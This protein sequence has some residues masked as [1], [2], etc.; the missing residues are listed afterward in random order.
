MFHWLRS[1]L[2]RWCAAGLLL[3]YLG[4]CAL[5]AAGTYVDNFDGAA[6]SIAARNLAFHGRYGVWD[7]QTFRCWPADWSTGPTLMLP[8]AATYRL[9]GDG[10]FTANYGC[11][12][13][14]L[15][16]LALYLVL[17]VR[18]VVLP[19]GF[20]ALVTA[21]GLLAAVTGRMDGGV[22]FEITFSR[23]C[24]EILAGLLLL[25]ATV[26]TFGPEPSRRSAVLGGT[27]AALAV[28]TKFVTVMPVACLAGTIGVLVLRGRKPVSTLVL[29]CLAAAA[30]AGSFELLKLVSL[31]SWRAYLVNLREFRQFLTTHGSSGLSAG[32]LTCLTNFRTHLAIFCAHLGNFTVPL[33]L[34]LLLLPWSLY[35]VL[36]S[37]DV[38]PGDCIALALG[39]QTSALFGWWFFLSHSEWVRHILPGLVLLPLW[40]AHLVSA[41]AERFSNPGARTALFGS[42]VLACLLPALSPG[43][44]EPIVWP[45]PTTRVTERTEALFRTAEKIKAL[46]ATH[47]D[48]RFFSAGF[49]RHWD[50]QSVT[51]VSLFDVLDPRTL[52]GP[53]DPGPNYLITSDLFNLEHNPTITELARA[54]SAR[55]VF[56]DGSFRIDELPAAREIPKSK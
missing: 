4:S 53:N 47:P 35:R 14:C 24:G 39:L 21:I 18:R 17:A 43:T 13:C 11:A 54:A 30:V 28:Y 15:S 33:L 6:Q 55:P 45:T 22:N 50:I 27:L 7:F 9:L 37:R 20:L 52:P 41:E 26:V 49:W 10:P 46:R 40:G 3:G 42:W 23:P 25:T 31:G 36:L 44:T 29:W 34:P 48:A 1:S 51:D 16:V 56:A 19:A 32:E 38:R 2:W 8:V 12:V 5:T